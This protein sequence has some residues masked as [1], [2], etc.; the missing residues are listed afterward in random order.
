MIVLLLSMLHVISMVSVPQRVFTGQDGVVQEE[1]KAAGCCFNIFFQFWNG[2]I[3]ALFNVLVERHQLL[4][5]PR[6]T[7]N[8]V[9][10]LLILL[11]D[12]GKMNIWPLTFWVFK[13]HEQMLSAFFLL[14]LFVKL[15]V[16]LSFRHDYSVFQILDSDTQVI[17]KITSMQT[18][19]GQGDFDGQQDDL[20]P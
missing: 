9:C 13:F 10:N 11:T 20:F 6:G 14:L 15:T 17:I 7:S 3:T 2:P 5:S 1:A 8:G 4:C 18:E 19:H 16:L 12:P